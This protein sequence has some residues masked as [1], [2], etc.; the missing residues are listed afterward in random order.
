MAAWRLQAIAEEPMDT[1][2]IVETTEMAEPWSVVEHLVHTFHLHRS[3]Q[4]GLVTAL[5]RESV[6]IVAGACDAGVI[7]AG[8]RGLETIATS[9]PVPEKLDSLQ[10]QLDAGPCLTAAREQAVVR[11]DDI[12]TDQRWD[13]FCTA[14][15]RSGVG[16][17][18]CLP[19]RVDATVLGTLSLYSSH[20][21]AFTDAEPTVRV[22]GVLAASTLAE[23]RRKQAFER[24]LSSRDLIGQAKG[25]L[26]YAH[27]IDA[28][29]AFRLLAER[30][31]ATNTKLVEIARSVAESGALL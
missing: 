9:G 28:D 1:P 10:H 8:R 5:C 12:A 14:A 25:I 22:L 27:R 31:K 16:S 20:P 13:G 24:A 6:R 23:L 15:L 19:L 4:F 7:V 30:S 29:T 21:R 26:M 3:D 11:V 2:E 18:L 17:M